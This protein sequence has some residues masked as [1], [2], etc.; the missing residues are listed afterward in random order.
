MTAP[1]LV[2]F[3]VEG[4]ADPSPLMRLRVACS[5]GELLG[6]HFYDVSSGVRYWP[7][8]EAAADQLAY[9]RHLA[10]VGLQ[11]LPL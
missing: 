9:L 4:L 1:H 3:E 5:C 2:R 11:D 10:A 6:E 8:S 7:E